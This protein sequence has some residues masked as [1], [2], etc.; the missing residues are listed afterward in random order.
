MAIKI[1]KFNPAAILILLENFLSNF[2]FFSFGS[3]FFFLI[4]LIFNTDV[5]DYDDII[6]LC[7]HFSFFIIKNEFYL[8]NSFIFW[9]LCLLHYYFNLGIILNDFL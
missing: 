7:S 8:I 9:K 5:F 4:R 6:N 2:A 3:L 1:P